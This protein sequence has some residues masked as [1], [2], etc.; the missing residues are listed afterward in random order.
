[1][2]LEALLQGTRALP[3][4]AGSCLGWGHDVVHWGSIVKGTDSSA[5]MEPRISIAVEFIA[6]R[7]EATS[8][9]QPTLSCD[10]MPTLAERLHAVGKCLARYSKFEPI[11]RFFLKS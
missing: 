10:G 4:R 3:A 2:H 5:R 11:M 8:W 6:A 9:E 7:Q 1:M